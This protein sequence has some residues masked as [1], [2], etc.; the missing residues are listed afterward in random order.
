M[1]K[2]QSAV[3]DATSKVCKLSTGVSRPD[4]SHYTRQEYLDEAENV[5]LACLLTKERQRLVGGRA[6]SSLAVALPD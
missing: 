6:G 5:V 3:P 4:K 1:P 2:S